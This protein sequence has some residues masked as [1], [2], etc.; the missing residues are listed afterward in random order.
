MINSYFNMQSFHI[1]EKISFFS[2][3]EIKKERN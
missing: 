3:S 1:I 2:N